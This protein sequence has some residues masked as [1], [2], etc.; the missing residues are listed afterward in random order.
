MNL[1]GDHRVLITGSTR[2][3]GHAAAMAF[4][5]HGA[6]VILH[7]RSDNAVKKVTSALSSLHPGKVSGFAADLSDRAA[8][9]GLAAAAGDLDVL[10]NC[11]GIYEE[12]MLGEADEEHWLTTIEVN[13]TAPW[14]L[15]RALLPGLKRRRGLIIN[16]GSDSALLG[17]SGA[18]AYCASKGALVG[19]TRALATELA[20]Q[21]RALCVC[22]GPI[23]TDM[24]QNSVASA[25]DPKAARRQWESYPLLKRVAT[26][27]E[28][29]EAIL[30][31]AS[32]A[33][34][35]QTGSLIIV[36][37][38]ATAGRRP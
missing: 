15:A 36:D 23:D 17:F 30:F 19:L 37:G 3:L 13:L 14:R 32:P 11:A 29:A 2:G 38:G 24:M 6:H 34:A 26:P 35:F 1:P 9:D 25:P 5:K 22:P 31:A 10:V 20:P 4:L 12:R 27:A 28:I 33:C 21:V 18:S 8:Q 16:V 7:G